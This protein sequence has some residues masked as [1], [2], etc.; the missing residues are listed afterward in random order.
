V[1][2]HVALMGPASLASGRSGGNVILVASDAPIPVGAILAADEMR[3]EANVL[4]SE[5]ADLDDWIGDA[6]VLT[7]DFA[8]VDQLLSEH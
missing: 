2:G 3:G 4:V 8:P 5:P 7:D 6:Q 1:F